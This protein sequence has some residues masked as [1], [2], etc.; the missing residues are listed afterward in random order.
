MS[1]NIREQGWR[2]AQVGAISLYGQLVK[3]KEDEE[4]S[5]RERLRTVY[6][7]RFIGIEILRSRSRTTLRRP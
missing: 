4:E 2:Q 1:V 7:A 3:A 5:T 6:L